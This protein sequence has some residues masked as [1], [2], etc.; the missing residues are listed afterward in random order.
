[1]IYRWP[2]SALGPLASC[3]AQPAIVEDGQ[4]YQDYLHASDVLEEARDLGVSGE[5]F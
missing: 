2:A 5:R 1:M 4:E 3:S